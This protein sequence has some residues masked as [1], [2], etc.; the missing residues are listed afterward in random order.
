MQNC[1]PRHHIC[2]LPTLRPL[3]RC[4]PLLHQ[5]RRRLYHLN[6][7][8]L[9]QD[10]LDVHRGH[11]SPSV[12]RVRPHHRNLQ[13]LVGQDTGGAFQELLCCQLLR[14]YFLV[15]GGHGEPQRSVRVRHYRLP[16]IGSGSPHLRGYHRRTA[17]YG[18]GQLLL[19]SVLFYND[20]LCHYRIASPIRVRY[21]LHHP[22]I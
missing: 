15:V 2:Q 7:E 18:R 22:F 12:L 20:N 16:R 9:G 13:D 3:P 8:L 5:H 1:S 21:R 6:E 4:R 17:H 19:G 10:H 14:F 11:R